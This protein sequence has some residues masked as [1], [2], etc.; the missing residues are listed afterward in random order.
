VRSWS[1]D[2]GSHVRKGEVLA[3]IEAP[4]VDQQLSQA[5]AARR[6]AAAS[7]GLAR[8]TA[9]RWESLRK[10]N[11]VSQQELQ[12]KFLALQ[13]TY[14]RLQKDLEEKQAVET[15][16]IFKKM[17]NVIAQIAQ[18]EGVTFVFEKNSGL[19][20]APASL[21]LTNELIRKYNAKYPGGAKKA[22]AAAPKKGDGPAAKKADAAPKK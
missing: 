14:V 13:E 12:Q 7:L 3:L 10:Q 2:I 1:K 4:E 16:K 9:E 22:E 21:D 17:T 19:L 8:S 11:V 18:A 20:Y 15:G 5:E 6:Q